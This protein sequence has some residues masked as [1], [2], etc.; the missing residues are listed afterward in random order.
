M[1]LNKFQCLTLK[2]IGVD[3][4]IYSK[5]INKKINVSDQKVSLSEDKVVD[6][7]RVLFSNELVNNDINTKKDSQNELNSSIKHLSDISTL[8]KEIANCKKCFLCNHRKNVVFGKGVLTNVACMIIGEAP[9]EY[10]DI[11]GKPFVGKSGKL[12]DLMLDSISISRTSN[13]FISN[14]V[15]CRP[16][17]NR[18]P[19]FEEISSCRPYLIE[20]IDLINPKTILALGKFAANALLCKDESI[21]N[22]RGKIHSF[23]TRK[24]NIPVVVSYHPAYLLRRPEEKP[25]SWNDLCLISSLLEK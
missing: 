22:M 9:G 15:K 1:S 11:E 8:K 21:R 2:E 23:N 12:L 14:I 17:G 16:P 5:F 20:Q 7:T 24:S 3:F 6:R 4:S 25:L 10:E 13:A 18:N 19:R